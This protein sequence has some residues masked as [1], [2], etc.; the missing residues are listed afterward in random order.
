MRT[1]TALLFFSLPALAADCAGLSSAKL[2]ETTITSAE[3]VSAGTYTPPYGN[4]IEGLPEF[5]RVAGVIRP[6]SDSEIRFEVWMPVA[7]WNEKYLGVGNG[8]F[9]G[10]IDFNQLA[11]NLKRGFAT[12]ATDTGHE[13][14]NVDAS[15]AYKHPEKVNDFGWRALHLT[16]ENAKRLVEMYYSAAPK[17]AYFDSCSDGGREALMEAQRFP[18]D[19]DGIIAGAPANYWTRLV[20]AG[21]ANFKVMRDNPAAYISAMKLPAIAKAT[22]GACDAQDGVKDGVIN[23]PTRCHFDPSVLLCKNGDALDCLTAPQVAFLKTIYAGASTSRGEPVFPGRTPG[24]ELGPGGWSGWILGNAPGTGLGTGFYENYFRYMVYDDPAWNPFT[25]NFDAALHTA[26][27]KT[28][29]ALNATDPDLHRFEAH[30]GKL[31]LY[32]GWNDPAIPAQNTVNYFKSVREKMGSAEVERFVR[33]Y[34]VPGMQHCIGG[35]GATTIG[36]FGTRTPEG[37]VFGAL[38]RWVEKGAAPQEIIATKYT[39]DNPGRGVQMT[40]PLCPYPQVAKYKGSGDT[41]DAHNF[42]CSA[43]E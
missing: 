7:G 38:E 11:G 19:F 2:P 43:G 20:A 40:R 29:R 30:G 12:A 13:A 16:T 28:A 22:L 42:V 31:I 4:P 21:T 14:D 35:P 27:E 24:G 15:W 36:Q 17:H 3:S 26:E 18:E 25:A 6:T 33:V 39:G 32:H 34:M 23:D 10:A 1:I 41:N 8:G 37:G 9:A 5:C